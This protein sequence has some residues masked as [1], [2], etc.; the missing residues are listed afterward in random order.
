MKLTK[1]SFELIGEKLQTAVKRFPLTVAAVLTLAG[2]IFVQIHSRENNYVD[3]RVWYFLPLGILASLA[4]YLFAEN[5]IR[6]ILKN[7]LNAVIV[8]LLALYAFTLQ[9]PVVEAEIIRSVML[10]VSFTLAIF[11]A[12]YITGKNQLKFWDYLQETFF[13]LVMA[14]FFGAVFMAGLSL[15]L[16]SLDQLFGV[17]IPD[18][19]YGYLATTCFAVFS[20]LYFLSSV[21]KENPTEE[22]AEI[23]FPHFLKILGLYILLPILGVYLVILYGYLIKIIASWQLPNGWVSW[24]VSVLGI[25]GYLTMFILYPISTLPPNPLKGGLKETDES[26]HS[27]MSDISSPFRGLGGFFTRFFPLL[28]LPLLILMFVGI[29]RRFSDYGI[30]INRLLVLILNLW[31]FGISIYLFIVKNRHIKWIFISFAMVAFLS[32]VGPWS[33]MKVTKSSMTSELKTLLAETRWNSSEKMD[34]SNLKLLTLKREKQERLRDIINYLSNKYGKDLIRPFYEKKLGNKATEYDFINALGVSE[35]FKQD[36]YFSNYHQSANIALDIKDYHQLIK[37]SRISSKDEYEIN[38]TLSASI[39]D[40]NLIISN[41]INHQKLKI[42]L[43]DI[44]QKAIERNKKLTDNK[45]FIVDGIDYKLIVYTI[46]GK[47]DNSNRLTIN[48]LEAIILLK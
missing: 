2:F 37:L 43:K 36:E 24:L 29:M 45:D 32:A 27:E 40:E 19:Y 10:G 28:L 13:Q 38:D 31:L 17:N 11:F 15:A 22:M 18:R 12:P 26:Q 35:D 1:I 14:F 25:A 4:F 48:N 33:V 16:V 5:R 8:G 44:V 42:S 7:I 23:S 46:D 6:C 9:K 20:P 30:T 47:K 34:T 3:Q 39:V 21:S 41:K